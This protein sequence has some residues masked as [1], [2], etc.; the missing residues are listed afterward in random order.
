MDPAIKLVTKVTIFFS[1]LFT[2]Y[3]GFQNIVT[4]IHEEEGNHFLGPFALAVNYAFFIVGN[5]FVSRFKQTS[6][7]WQMTFASLGYFSFYI[8]GFII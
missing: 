1:I 3:S 5:F 6:E 4:K 8:S 7:K 2:A